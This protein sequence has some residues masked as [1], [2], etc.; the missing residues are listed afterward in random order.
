[1]PVIGGKAHGS[2]KPRPP[3]LV[4]RPDGSHRRMPSFGGSPTPDVSRSGAKV[5]D[6]SGNE[7]GA[8]R[9]AGR[10]SV[11]HRGGATTGGSWKETIQEV[12]QEARGIVSEVK[13]FV[14][15]FALM[16][17]NEG[18]D[19]ARGDGADEYNGG[20]FSSIGTAI[21]AMGNDE[22]LDRDDMDSGAFTAIDTA[23]KKM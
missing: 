7:Q 11:D 15:D 8:R 23:L 21:R 3:T 22:D 20:V 10:A 17:E 18:K 5:D 2:Q 6:G 1:M 19:R 12:L 9:R 4:E 14:G 16:A 13:D